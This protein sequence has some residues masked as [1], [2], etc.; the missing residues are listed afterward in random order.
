MTI[1]GRGW[2]ADQNSYGFVAP[3]GVIVP[4]GEEFLSGLVVGAQYIRDAESADTLPVA[5]CGGDDSSS[6]SSG[7]SEWCGAT[8][9]KVFT[10][11]CQ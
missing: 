7:P 6:G 1:E 11:V 9:Q 4:A 10:Y 2:D 5:F 3:V 8:C